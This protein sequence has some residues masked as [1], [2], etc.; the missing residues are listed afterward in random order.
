MAE[1]KAGL[2]NK[3]F[4]RW[5]DLVLTYPKIALSVGILLTLVSVIII[6]TKFDIRS[7]IKDLMPQ[8]AQVVQDLYAISDRMGSV[9]TLKVY[10]KTPEMVALT[11]EQKNGESY[12][13]CL[14]RIGTSS[15]L[16]D[17]PI[18]G[19]N[20]C[21]NPLMLYALAFESLASSL[22]SVGTVEFIKD[23][24]FFENN[25]LL[26]A[27]TAEL[28]RAYTQ[29]DE[30]LTQARRMS[31]EYKACLLTAD[32]DAECDA[33][34]PDLKKT[35]I[36]AQSADGDATAD[37]QAQLK[38]RYEETELAAIKEFPFYPM[39][40]GGY[41]A[42]LEIRFKDST[43]G[44][45][46]IQK[47]IARIDEMLKTMDMS[48]YDDRISVEYGGGFNDMKEE[49]NAIVTD[50]AQSIGLTIFSIFALI[51]IF[52][53]SIRAT[54]RIFITLL[55]STSWALGITFAAIGYLNMITA[56]IFAILL[57]LGIDFGIH[58][59]SRYL[60]ERRHGLPVDDALKISIVETGSPLFFGAMTTA[61]AF[62]ALM[63]G[64]FPG[65]S[66]FG[67]VAGLGVIFAFFAMTTIM[68]SLVHISER[69]K[70]SQLKTAQSRG[71]VADATRRRLIPIVIS[72]SLLVLGCVAYCATQI[73]KIQFED[74][75]YNLQL[76]PKAKT[77]ATVLK[78]EKYVKNSRPSSPAIVVLD[79]L[80]QVEALE[81]VLKRDRE[82]TNFHLIRKVYMQSGFAFMQTL[83]DI[84]AQTW[85]Y[86]GQMRS[87]PMMAAVTRTL[88]PAAYDL[89]PL[90]ATYGHEKS[91]G[92]RLYR[93]LALRMPETAKRL[94]TLA[95]EVLSQNTVANA[96]PV[97]VHMQNHLPEWLWQALPKQRSS[98]QL[99]SISDFASIFSYL[100]GTST[101]QAERLAVIE[102]IRER[103]AD[104][105]IRFLP[106]QEKEKIREFRK[107][108]IDHPIAIDDLPDWV[109]LQFKEGGQHP[110]PPRPESNVDYAFGNIAVLYQST[111]TYNGAQAE[112]LTREARSI[113][114]DDKPLTVAT[115]AF[116]YAD[117]LKLVKTDGLQIAIV[118]LAVI[119]LLAIIQQRR[120]FPALIVTLPVISGIICTVAI[121]V[122]FDLK[123]GLFNIVMLPVTMGIG[124]DGAIYLFERYRQLGKGS[125][126]EAVRVV[127]L[128]VFMSSA[129]TLVG[130][131]GMVMSRHMGLNS[132]GVL[133]IIGIS[134]CFFTT[135]LIQP[136]LI[137]LSEKF[138]IKSV[139]PKFNYTP[140]AA[141]ETP[142]PPE[143]IKTEEKSA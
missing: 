41:M 87:L 73:E 14:E 72:V 101:Q 26:Y 85:A 74:N 142:I 128:P 9:T 5:I 7:D 24:T 8:D 64:S 31:G 86:T 51:A 52:F 109:K 69:I 16:R 119:L 110:L 35:D 108:L 48:A 43:T 95:P 89:V 141:H 97:I 100:P 66:Q 114:I 28:E 75:F 19:E 104:R 45:K 60:L 77:G 47:E 88:P 32:N 136:G 53:R 113:R 71:D 33:L 40:N 55:M 62:F 50:I 10:V 79:N 129:T 82:Y 105:Q 76:K 125:C 1:K 143:P 42:A 139:V 27:E 103:T 120:F 36:G 3:I 17:K 81:Q 39:Q 15:L 93:T 68:P 38:S 112:M 12:R 138:G 44:L 98:Q 122:F 115:G 37:A 127:F 91:E 121:M 70:P 78:T 49:Y 80:D 21:D 58:L 137:L 96:L 126:I 107:Y 67:F 22:D 90:F 57:G 130:F 6:A 123:L 25:I 46:S 23:K 13:A 2:S 124:I 116:V 92:L 84:F 18:V 65:F 111:S 99:N 131:G 30:T 34:K 63:L 132:M 4:T 54:L 117:M 140:N 11:P 83:D 133:A 59:Y 61:V 29:I 135:F 94:T 118:A 102:K 20:W 106:E 134:T 56:F